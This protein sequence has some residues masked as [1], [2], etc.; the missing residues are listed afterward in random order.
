MSLGAAFHWFG[1]S[2]DHLNYISFYDGLRYEL[3]VVDS[4]FEPGFVLLSWFFKYVLNA[5]YDILVLSIVA[6][7][8]AI[9]FYLFFRYLKSPLFAVAAYL[10]LFYPLH[11]YTQIRAALSGSLV[12]FAAHTFLERRYY[13]SVA[14]LAGAVAFHASAIIVA[15]GVAVFIFV[16][17]PIGIVFSFIGILALAVWFEEI[18]T[19]VTGVLPYI[20]PLATRYLDNTSAGILPN[21]WS[22][23]NVFLMA[24]MC[25]IAFITARS[26][27]TYGS[28]FMFLSLAGLLMLLVFASSPV[29]AQRGKELLTISTI[30][31]VFYGQA[32]TRYTPFALMLLGGAWSVY[33]A[34]T[35]GILGG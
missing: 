19:I 12:Y 25:S 10:M 26:R 15:I 13:P 22:V 3:T 8:L 20:N 17:R 30:F 27:T 32:D 24:A 4:R 29:L 23:Q 14:L 9:K 31:L 7:S 35:L 6:T 28:M 16:R 34:L 21:L 11:E 33:R 5:S 1:T 2:V 18:V